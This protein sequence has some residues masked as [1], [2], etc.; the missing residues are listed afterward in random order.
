MKLERN[1]KQ[2]N[3]FCVR[4]VTKLFFSMSSV[5]MSQDSFLASVWLQ[6]LPS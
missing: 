2:Q 6:T 5:N 4:S 1:K 3:R